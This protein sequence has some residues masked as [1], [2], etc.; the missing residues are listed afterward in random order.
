MGAAVTVL[1]VNINR[2]G[3]E[4]L[5][6]QPVRDAI[7]DCDDIRFDEGRDAKLKGLPDTADRPVTRGDVAPRPARERTRASFV[8]SPP[9]LDGAC[10]LGGEFGVP[11]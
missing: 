9:G 4:V 5:V 6:S 11:Q 10:D 8:R 2:P 1:D 7:G 3:G